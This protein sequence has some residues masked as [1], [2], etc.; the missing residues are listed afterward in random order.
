[1]KKLFGIFLCI[2]AVISMQSIVSAQIGYSIT[3]NNRDVTN[4]DQQFY[5][6]DLA[7]GQGTLIAP[8]TLNGQVIRREYEGLASAG[9]VLFGVAEFDTE[10]CNTGSDPITGLA[11]DVRIFR[12]PGTYPAPNGVQN[13]IGPQI[14]ETCFP[15]GFTET[16]AGYNA[17][18]GFIY[19]IASDDLLPSSA[20]R[21]RLFR[22]SPTNG[23]ATQVGAAAGITLTTGSGGDENPYF[24]GFTVLPDGRAFATEAR[25]TNNPTQSPDPN[26]ADNGGLYRVFLTGPNAGR[27][28]FVKYLLNSD[29]NRDTGLAN[30]QNGT[31]YLLLE[32]GR[33]WTTGADAAS[34]VV[35]AVFPLGSPA[36]SNTLSTPGC[37]RPISFPGQFCGD[38]EGFDIP[39]PGLR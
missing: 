22:I 1:M 37:L 30:T 5:Q 36:G 13:A 14:G 21:S 28:T 32:D 25:F 3:D 39:A 2:V 7:T 6:F 19:A 24:D 16:A 33:V 34:P 31:I 26:V 11:S 12:V 17:V 27:A 29:V 9:S 15:S 4:L 23:L 18:D 8:L 35:P 38:L 10:L 20:P